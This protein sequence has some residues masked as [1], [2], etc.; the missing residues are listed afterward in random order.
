MQ[1]SCEECPA[2][3]APGLPKK[4]VDEVSVVYTNGLI[5]KS[6]SWEE[7]RAVLAASVRTGLHQVSLAAVHRELLRR[8]VGP[9]ELPAW[10]V[11]PFSAGPAYSACTSPQTGAVWPCNTA[12]VF[13]QG[14]DVEVSLQEG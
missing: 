7:G 13:A 3:T 11:G 2:Q 8:A 5:E 4:A 14:V 10:Q 12:R 1:A 6:R 9:E